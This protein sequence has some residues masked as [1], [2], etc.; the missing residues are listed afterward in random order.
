MMTD[1][2]T[3]KLNWVLLLTPALPPFTK[4]PT[5]VEGGIWLVE[6]SLDAMVNYHSDFQK[7]N[8]IISILLKNMVNW[9]STN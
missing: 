6:C 8:I 4:L 1:K 3:A 2:F 9:I 5:F 7:K